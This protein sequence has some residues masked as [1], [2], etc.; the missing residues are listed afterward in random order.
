VNAEYESL[1]SLNRDHQIAICK[2]LGLKK[3]SGANEEQLIMKILKG[4][5]L[6]VRNKGVTTMDSIKKK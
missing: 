2:S 4:W 6:W 5:K 1:K 3:Y